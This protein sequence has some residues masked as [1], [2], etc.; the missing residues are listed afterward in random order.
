MGGIMAD[1]LSFEEAK[2]RQD[3]IKELQNQIKELLEQKP[4]HKAFQEEVEKELEKA[5]DNIHNREAVLNNLAASK[6]RELGKAL[7]AFRDELMKIKKS[8]EEKKD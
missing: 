4:E 1:V 3:K 6:F 5:G 2:K 8:L 7:E